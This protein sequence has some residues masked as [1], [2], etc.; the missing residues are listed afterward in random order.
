[1]EHV[2]VPDEMYFLTFARSRVTDVNYI[3]RQ[4]T[5]VHFSPGCGPDILSL[6]MVQAIDNEIFFARKIDFDDVESREF[7]DNERRKY[8]EYLGIDVSK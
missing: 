3:N 5:Y 6:D 8:D 1:M 7:I 2:N 4:T